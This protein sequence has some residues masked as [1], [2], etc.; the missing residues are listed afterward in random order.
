MLDVTR[1]IH[2]LR[3]QIPDKDVHPLGDLS[4]CTIS[5][6]MRDVSQPMNRANDQEVSR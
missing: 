2:D 1:R 6:P 5:L 3:L 4:M